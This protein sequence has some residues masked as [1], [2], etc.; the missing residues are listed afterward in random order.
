MIS[1]TR[2]DYWRDSLVKRAFIG[3]ASSP[4][5]GNPAAI[6]LW[7]PAASGKILICNRA[8]FMTELADLI[9]IKYYPTVFSSTGHRGN[10]Y[11][12]EAQPVGLIKYQSGAALGSTIGY[13]QTTAGNMMKTFRFHDPILIPE[14]MGLCFIMN[15]TGHRATVN[16]EWIEA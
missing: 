5:T 10:K 3:G 12:G 6:Q 11:L 15:T 14:D 2:V 16:F 8:V 13:L 7:N 1:E 9:Y 4:G